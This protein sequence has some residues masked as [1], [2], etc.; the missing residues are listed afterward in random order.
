M[1]IFDGLGEKSMAPLLLPYIPITIYLLI[2]I[3]LP[4]ILRKSTCN[5]KARKRNRLDKLL[6]AQD[7]ENPKDSIKKYFKESKKWPIL[8]ALNRLF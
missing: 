7:F 4:V 2:C 8:L 1:L 5:F 3:T 6:N